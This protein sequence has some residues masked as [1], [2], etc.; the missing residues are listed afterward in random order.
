MRRP[1][2]RITTMLLFAV[3]WTALANGQQKQCLNA[4]AV[5][6]LC[7]L[8]SKAAEYNG[9]EIKVRGFYRHL[10]HGAILSSPG[11]PHQKINV[12]FVKKLSG[13]K[14]DLKTLGALA[15]GHTATEVVFRA[16][17]NMAHEGQCFGQDCDPY[18]IEAIE[19]S[20]LG[21]QRESAGPATVHLKLRG[22]RDKV[23]NIQ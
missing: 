7:S 4:P 23:S 12:R 3:W 17:F 14:D 9:K 6:P 5:I 16:R 20:C 11:C 8:A 18:E 21:R 19:L 15:D 22:P 10:F 2:F 1:T 13:A